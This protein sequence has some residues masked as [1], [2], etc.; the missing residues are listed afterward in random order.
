VTDASGQFAHVTISG[1]PSR[2]DTVLSWSQVYSEFRAVHRG[3][4]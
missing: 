2:P 1:I 3:I 4:V